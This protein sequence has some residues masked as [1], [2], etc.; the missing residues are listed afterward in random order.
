MDFQD[1]G[2]IGE[3]TAAVATI[4]TLLYLARQIQLGSKTIQTANLG[5][6]VEAMSAMHDTHM[7]I[8]DVFEAAN[9]NSREL[10]DREVSA[11]HGH[12]VQMFLGFETVFL[13][14]LNETVDEQYFDAR[15]KTVRRAGTFPYFA[16]WFR[17][18]G[19]DMYDDRFVQFVERQWSDVEDAPASLRLSSAEPS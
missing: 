9:L 8:V 11:L 15:A 6:M 10:T 1:I 4:V 13:F 14:H 19:P 3:L 17:E 12:C 2:A 18:W 7:Q 16:Q 5:T